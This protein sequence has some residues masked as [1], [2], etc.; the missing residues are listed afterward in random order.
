MWRCDL[1]IGR[2]RTALLPSSPRKSAKGVGWNR[3][4]V[5]HPRARDALTATNT[6]IGTFTCGDR[7]APPGSALYLGKLRAIG[8]S[9]FNQAQCRRCRFSFGGNFETTFH[10][11]PVSWRAPRTVCAARMPRF[12]S[13]RDE[14]NRCMPTPQ[15]TLRLVKKQAR[16]WSFRTNMASILLEAF[17]GVPAGRCAKSRRPPAN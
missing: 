5:F 10:P 14:S 16:H 9:V 7:P 8:R 15:S 12:F 17:G 11:D 2:S 4:R 3:R 6:V 1:P 13:R